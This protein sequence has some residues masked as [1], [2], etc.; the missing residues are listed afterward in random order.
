MKLASTAT[1]S[2][3]SRRLARAVATVRTEMGHRALRH[4]RG[5]AVGA[6]L[7]ARRAVDQLRDTPRLAGIEG[8]F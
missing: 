5:A 1:T 8:G 3:A 2:S 7:R 4:S 6:A